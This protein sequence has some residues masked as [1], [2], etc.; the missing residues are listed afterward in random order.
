MINQ[1]DRSFMDRRRCAS[2]LVHHMLLLDGGST[3]IFNFVPNSA[4]HSPLLSKLWTASLSRLSPAAV[5]KWHKSFLDAGS[6][7]ITTNTYQIPPISYY[8]DLD[9]RDVIIDA[10]G[11][12]L[13]AVSEHGEG[14]V[15]LS[16]G[17]RN[18]IVGKREYDCAPLFS[19]EEYYDF[20]KERLEDYQKI[21]GHL[22][23]EITYLAFETISS[24]EEA[25]AILF[26]L[27]DKN[28][29]SIIE[30][31]KAWIT[32]SVGDASIPRITQ[33]LSKVVKDPNIKYLWGIGFNCVGIDI[34]GDLAR[35]LAKMIQ[36]MD[37]DLRLVLYPDAGKFH[38][39]TTA[40]F[41]DNA[42]PLEDQDVVKW[43][44]EIGELSQL[45]GGK[46]I[47]GGCC[48]TDA[49]FIVEL[50]RVSTTVSQ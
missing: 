48:N 22:F 11:L 35:A 1:S 40:Q 43:A 47:L 9:I 36:T 33:L 15:A 26:I 16:L 31:K 14:A 20:H 50:R 29:S 13:N 17:T 6:N 45:N 23:A 8:P 34:A 28:A 42:V 41:T 2:L 30:A 7:I 3:S 5:H 37:L 18:S 46:V 12:A 27:A 21:L 32:F 24:Y 38:E 49:R 10:V 4:P 44:S 25:E 39:K 19:I